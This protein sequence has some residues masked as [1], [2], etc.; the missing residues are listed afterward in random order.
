MRLRR[1]LPYLGLVVLLVVYANLHTIQF[2]HIFLL[3]FMLVLGLVSSTTRRF[4]VA[5]AHLIAFG[6]I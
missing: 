5:V 4:L 1:V 6:W 2:E 3:T